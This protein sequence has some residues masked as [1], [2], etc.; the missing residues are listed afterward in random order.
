MTVFLQWID[1]LWLIPALLAMRKGQR[2]W[3]AG[4]IAGCMIMMRLQVELMES[5]G[6]PYGM[7][8]L[9][10]LHVFYRGLAIYGFFYAVY[11]VTARF[12]PY[13]RG[14]ILLAT[15][16]SFFFAALVVSMLGMVL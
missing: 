4:F 13:A 3:A 5:M 1:A 11:L 16:I 7:F 10:R 12:S 6:Y 14:P 8:S 9:W 2:L 15:S